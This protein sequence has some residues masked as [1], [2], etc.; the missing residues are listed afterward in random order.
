MTETH[1]PD[2]VLIPRPVFD[3]APGEIREVVYDLIAAGWQ[4][5]HAAQ[6]QKILNDALEA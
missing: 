2:M 5:K 3:F 1:E 6:I 4:E